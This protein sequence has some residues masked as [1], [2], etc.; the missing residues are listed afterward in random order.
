MSRQR[1]PVAPAATVATAGT[2]VP[3]P[4]APLA[5]D[6]APSPRPTSG[7]PAGA[8]SFTAAWEQ[9]L[10]ELELEV[11][12]AEDLLGRLHRQAELPPA[13]LRQPW[14]P[15]AG[16][17]PLPLPLADRARAL[18]DRQA[19]VAEALARAMVLNRRQARA[20]GAL[21][22]ARAQQRAPQGAVYLDLAL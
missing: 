18:A 10:A 21:A 9:A 8:G 6:L 17:G 3:G 16:L 20:A 4:R 5:A 2:F 14:A 12:A 19:H 15:P 11:S 7:P 22:D 13:T 1:T